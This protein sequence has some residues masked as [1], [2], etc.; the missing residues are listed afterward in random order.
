MSRP[1]LVFLLLLIVFTSQ[2]DWNQQ[3]V[4]EV[5]AN[6]DLSRKHLDHVSNQ[7]S[8]KEKVRV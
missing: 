4:N 1:I 5:E 8:V 3:I 6:P 2:I 7:D